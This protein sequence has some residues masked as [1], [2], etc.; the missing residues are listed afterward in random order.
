MM[1]GY[2]NFA[3]DLVPSARS[4]SILHQQVRDSACLYIS[5]QPSVCLESFPSYLGASCETVI[6]FL[7][8]Y[9]IRFYFVCL[10]LLCFNGS[11]TSKDVQI[12]GLN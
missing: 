12:D 4:L 9:E 6:N 5:L 10:F 1:P 2:L 7:G 8:C 11:F 3:I